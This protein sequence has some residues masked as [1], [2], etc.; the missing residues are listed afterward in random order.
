MERGREGE[1]EG[2][3]MI[4]RGMH[5]VQNPLSPVAVQLTIADT[6]VMSEMVGVGG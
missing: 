5:L 4:K 6:L 2:G 3:S 1:R